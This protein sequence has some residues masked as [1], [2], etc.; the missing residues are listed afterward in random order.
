[1]R[2][3]GFVTLLGPM[4]RRS[5][6]SRDETPP[7]AGAHQGAG[8][9]SFCWCKRCRAGESEHVRAILDLAAALETLAAL[10]ARGALDLA[11]ALETLAA[12]EARGALVRDTRGRLRVRNLARSARCLVSN[13]ITHPSTTRPEARA[14]PE[15]DAKK[16]P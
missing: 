9:L 12:L 1:V 16:G 6:A 3:I 11:A 13:R 5:H 4:S 15:S 10:E 2:R 14:A 7:P 8:R